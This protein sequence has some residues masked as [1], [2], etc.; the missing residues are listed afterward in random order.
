MQQQQI[1]DMGSED[2]NYGGRPSDSDLSLDEDKEAV[3]RESQRQALS[4]LEKAR[5]KPV[6]F[7]VRTNVSFDGSLDDD[8]PVQGYAISFNAKD[9]L[10]IKEKYSNDWWI[11]RVVKEGADVGFIPSPAKLESTRLQP[12]SS[13]SKLMANSSTRTSLEQSGKSSSFLNNNKAATL[14]LNSKS[15]Y[16]TSPRHS[17]STSGLSSSSNLGD[18]MGLP[19][20]KSSNNS[21]GSTPP[22]PVIEYLSNA[23]IN[24]VSS[25]RGVDDQNGVDEGEETTLGNSLSMSNKTNTISPQ[26]KEKR[27]FFKKA[28][29]VPPYEVVPSMRPLVLV[30]PSLKGYEVTD[31]MQKALFDYLKRKFEGRICITN[32]KADIALAKRQIMN[33]KTKHTLPTRTSSTVDE[34]R[35]EIDRIFE[36]SRRLQLVVLDCDTINHPTQLQKTSLAPIIVYLKISSPKVL[37]RLIKSRN[38]SQ[39]RNMNVQMVA[40]DKLAQCSPDL[41][42]VILD[43]NQLEEACEHLAEY[44]EAYWKATHPTIPNTQPRPLQPV[45]LDGSPQQNISRSNAN[46]NKDRHD[47]QGMEPVGMRESP[48]SHQQDYRDDQ[49]GQREPDRRDPRNDRRPMQDV[50]HN[51]DYYQDYDTRKDRNYDPQYERDRYYERDARR[52]GGPRSDRSMPRDRE[53]TLDPDRVSDPYARDRH[54]SERD[55]LRYE[56]EVTRDRGDRDR[57]NRNEQYEMQDRARDRDRYIDQQPNGRS[58][59]WEPQG[60]VNEYERRMPS[61]PYPDQYSRY[62]DSH[63]MRE[64]STV[65]M[66]RPHPTRP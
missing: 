19:T 42:D 5:T 31:M 16:P 38:K 11:G 60:P 18:V 14:P 55:T 35:E 34:V 23:L 6:A 15:S 52:E 13:R 10:H 41:F 63:G 24:T 61:A 29:N 32:V 26:P 7:A 45:P 9:F 3:R 36:L 25:L 1:D 28:E 22:T 39:S 48:H 58:R 66:G 44:L 17:R 21:R 8:S 20:S 64:P 47:G 59:H 27:K 56:H 50:S 2:S 57:Y 51:R 62:G 49:R 54:Y 12:S 37:Q 53:R 40:A 4:Q 65:G 46:R 33:P 30:G 43:E